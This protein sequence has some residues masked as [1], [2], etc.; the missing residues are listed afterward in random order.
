MPQPDNHLI[1]VEE[2]PDEELQALADLSLADLD[3]AVED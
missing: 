3:K 1:A 2:G